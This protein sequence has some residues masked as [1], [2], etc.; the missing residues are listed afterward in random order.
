MTHEPEL[1]LGQRVYAPHHSIF[2]GYISSIGGVNECSI[3]VMNIDTG[4]DHDFDADAFDGCW[5]E[6]NKQWELES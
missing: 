6:D 2:K 3:Y 5:N 1:Q 4:H